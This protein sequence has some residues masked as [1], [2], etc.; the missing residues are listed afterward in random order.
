MKE[1]V[2]TLQGLLSEIPVIT[3]ELQEI[4]ALLLWTSTSKATQTCP[5]TSGD[6]LED[7]S[8]NENDGDDQSSSVVGA[9]TNIGNTSSA[10]SLA[11]SFFPLNN[12]EKMGEKR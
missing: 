5:S 8:N 2:I 11:D 9:G 6:E 12:D 10:T 1:L 7:G 3:S 4:K